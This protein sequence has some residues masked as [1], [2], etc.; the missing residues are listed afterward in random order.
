MH[1]LAQHQNTSDPIIHVSFTTP[2]VRAFPEK[3]GQRVDSQNHVD[4]EQIKD[5]WSEV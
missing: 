5:L 1:Q 2:R 4:R 3:G